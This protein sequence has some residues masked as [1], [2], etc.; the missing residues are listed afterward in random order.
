MTFSSPTPPVADDNDT[1]MRTELKVLGVLALPRE[2]AVWVAHQRGVEERQPEVV[3]MPIRRQGESI[4]YA[5]DGHSLYLTSERQPT[6][7]WI[8]ERTP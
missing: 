3:T 2:D 8:V 6:P 7:L 5:A 1:A 4:C